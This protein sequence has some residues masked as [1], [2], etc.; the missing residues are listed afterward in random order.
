MPAYS[1]P[2]GVGVVDC[3]ICFQAA[4][5]HALYGKYSQPVNT[6]LHH[7][8]LKVF[9][10]MCYVSLRSLSFHHIFL[11]SA[12]L[13]QTIMA[14]KMYASG[15]AETEAERHRKSIILGVNVQGSQQLE[16]LLMKRSR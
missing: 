9:S 15:S 10:N 3:S 12:E 6:P 11:C 1:E 7:I 8:E 5:I 2:A 13:L 4:D 14:G 16:E